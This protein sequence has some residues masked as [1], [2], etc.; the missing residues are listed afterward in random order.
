VRTQKRRERAQ[1][2]RLPLRQA[3]R[4]NQKWSM[5]KG[6]LLRSGCKAGTPS[7]LGEFEPS[8]GHDRPG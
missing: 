2:Q 6:T 8:H 7:A 3:A 1:R 4:P 5:D